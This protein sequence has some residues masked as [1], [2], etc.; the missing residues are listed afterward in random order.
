[1]ERNRVVL[2]KLIGVA[3]VMMVVMSGFSLSF[4]QEY[5]ISPIP[6]VD[7]RGNIYSFQADQ[8][9]K[10]IDNP[11]GGEPLL[12]MD[13]GKLH[14]EF[15]EIGKIFNVKGQEASISI[16]EKG[17]LVDLIPEIQPILFDEKK[18]QEDLIQKVKTGDYTPYD[19][20]F[21]FGGLPKKTA[22]DLKKINAVLG[23]YTTRFNTAEEQRTGNIALGTSFINGKVLMPEEE[24]SFLNTA[25]P[26]SLSR[27][28]KN[29]KVILDGDFVDGIAGGACQISTTLFNAVLT[30]GL[31]VTSRRS[32][33]LAISYVP[34]G[35][36][37]AVANGLDFRFR[38]NLPNP[39]YLQ[40][41]VVNNQVTFKI[42]GNVQDY[43][44]VDIAVR[45]TG[46]R[47]YIL[48]RTM[49]GVSDYFY[50][51]YGI[52]KPKPIQTP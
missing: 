36:D 22:E 34:R 9:F 50:S 31:E 29:A 35:M 26:L 1:M 41:Y 25:G 49:D 33:S 27:G 39:I 12:Q 37:A 6:I 43:K 48:T 32:H 24:F 28:Y 42:Y 21:N 4:A 8:V 15:L 18:A 10:F 30:S 11:A 40:G 16:N 52:R 51:G 44:K 13:E 19:L 17:E 46:E 5:N 23:Q 20:S 47:K 3:L 14:R 38:N 45:N 2:R 7:L